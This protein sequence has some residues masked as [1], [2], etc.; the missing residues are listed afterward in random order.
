MSELIRIPLEGGGSVLVES[1]TRGP[2]G[3]VPATRDGR[4]RM[5]EA[6]E[7]LEHALTSVRRASQAVLTEL[8]KAGP[9]E[10]EVEFGVTLSAEAGAFIA[11]VASEAHLTVTLLWKRADAPPPP[12]PSAP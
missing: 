6:A 9:D 10:I 5:A 1:A 2:G 8:G 12:P 11:K 4:P 3:P 7:T